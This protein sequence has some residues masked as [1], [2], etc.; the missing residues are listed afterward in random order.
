M[1]QSLPGHLA[2]RSRHANE[3]ASIENEGPVVVWLKSSLRVHENP[4]LDVGRIIANLYDR[5]L[6]VYQAVDERYPWAS[7]RHH[8]MLLDGAVDLHHGCEALGLRYVL[9]LAREGNR[10][11]VMN[12]FAENAG[13]I[14]TDLFPL[15]PWSEWV[16]GVAGKATCPLIEVDCHCVIPMTLYGRSVDR[17]FKFRSATKKLRKRLLGEAWKT[18]DVKTTPYLGELPFNPINIVSDIENLSRRFAL[19]KE[20]EIDPTVLPVWE[21]RGGEMMGLTRWQRFKDKGLRSYAKR[22]NNAADPSGVSRMSASFHYGFVSPMMVARE[23]A[24]V[25]TKSSE[26]Y[27]DELLIFRE[28]AWHH[29][30]SLT[31]PYDVSNLPE[32]AS[33]SWAETADDPRPNLQEDQNL[34]FALSPSHL[35]NLCQ[36]SLLWH[37]ELHNNLRMTWGKGFPPWTACLEKSLELSQKLNDKYALDGRDP[38]SIAGVQWCHGLF[39]RAF[40]PSA[41]IMGTVRQR[42]IDAHSSR[43]D[44]EKYE[45]HVKRGYDDDSGVVMVVGPG[46]ILD[47]VADVLIDNGLK[48]Y[49]LVASNSSELE[50]FPFIDGDISG[51]IGERVARCSE[52]RQGW[53]ESFSKTEVAAV[54]HA[55]SIDVEKFIAS[56][57]MVLSEEALLTPVETQFTDVPSLEKTTK[58]ALW[59]LAGTVWDLKSSKNKARFSVQKKLF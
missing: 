11:P 4:A 30:S 18:V 42:S 7:L 49:R 43:I 10:Q 28:H 57:G 26:K 17:P 35:W 15:P 46:A 48:A 12:F 13:C 3:R 53:D 6:L 9:H 55:G 39:D 44:L 56:S 40:H 29:A 51:Y 5:P 2:D 22:R 20:C 25:G 50:L 59:S 33:E 16:R 32:W 27:L 58:E 47:M 1:L 52:R 38:S 45:A 24:A 19:L 34:E 14:I 36:K 23:A 8:N 31:N 54:I 37:G 21:E 41:P